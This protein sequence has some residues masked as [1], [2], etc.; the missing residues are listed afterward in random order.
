[1]GIKYWAWNDWGNACSFSFYLLWS[2]NIAD[3]TL[4][5]MQSPVRWRSWQ[6]SG[7]KFRRENAVHPDWNHCSHCCN[8]CYHSWP[9]SSQHP[10]VR[11]S[12][13]YIFAQGKLQ[14]LI[15]QYY[16]EKQNKCVCVCVCA[17]W[18]ITDSKMCFSYCTS[19]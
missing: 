11:M 16:N 12:D 10:K 19:Q 14:S 17:C 8:I 3:M 1:M 15:Y 6:T 13:V 9:A 18:N 2:W 5:I 7:R 4:Y